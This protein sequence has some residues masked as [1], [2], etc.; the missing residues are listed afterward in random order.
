MNYVIYDDELIKKSKKN[1]ESKKS[2]KKHRIKQ[3]ES[4]RRNV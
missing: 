1:N 3:N 4:L 2:E